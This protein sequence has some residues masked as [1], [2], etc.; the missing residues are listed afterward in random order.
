[1][2][3]KDYGEGYE[4]EKFIGNNVNDETICF[5]IWKSTF[6]SILIADGY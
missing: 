1:M 5:I 2:M 3:E 6:D 4:N